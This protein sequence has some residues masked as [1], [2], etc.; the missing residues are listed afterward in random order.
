[1]HGFGLKGLEDKKIKSA[2]YEV[3]W[4]AHA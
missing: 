4:L 1:M 3:A 2:L